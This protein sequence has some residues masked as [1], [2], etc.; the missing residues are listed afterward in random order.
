MYK[1]LKS[2]QTDVNG[3]KHYILYTKKEKRNANL[4]RDAEN[5]ISLMQLLIQTPI[6][7][8]VSEEEHLGK[9]MA[10]DMEQETTEPAGDAD[11][12]EQV[13]QGKMP[14]QAEDMEN[15]N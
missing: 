8:P 14:E 13:K 7:A 12:A 15:N 2:I 5:K 1:D 11:T 9:A 3:D 6:N 4:R 10:A